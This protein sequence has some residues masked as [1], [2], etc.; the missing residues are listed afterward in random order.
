LVFSAVSG[1]M[2]ALLLYLALRMGCSAAISLQGLRLRSVVGCGPHL[3]FIG[4]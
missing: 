4:G 1:L 3:W 2:L